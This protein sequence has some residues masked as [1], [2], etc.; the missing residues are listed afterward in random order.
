MMKTLNRSLFKDWK[1][2]LVAAIYVLSDFITYAHQHPEFSGIVLFA[3]YI[4]S[5]NWQGT[6]IALGLFLAGDSRKDLD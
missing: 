1:T 6:L 4:T 2:S 5:D 3:H